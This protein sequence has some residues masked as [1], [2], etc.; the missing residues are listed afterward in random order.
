MRSAVE[1]KVASNSSRETALSVYANTWLNRSTR[2]S[3]GNLGRAAV[4]VFHASEYMRKEAHSFPSDLLKS[5]LAVHILKQ[6]TFGQT[7]LGENRHKIA[8]MFFKI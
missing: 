1:E 7:R 3:F 6:P 4:S 8:G 5:P 2:E